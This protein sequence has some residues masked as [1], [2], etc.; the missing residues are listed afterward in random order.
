MLPILRALYDVYGPISVIRNHYYCGLYAVSTELTCRAADCD[1]HLDTWEPSGIPEATHG[2]MFHAAAMEGLIG[3]SIH[4]GIR[5]RLS[6]IVSP[7]QKFSESLSLIKVQQSRS[8][9]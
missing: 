4:L 3:P 8:A 7:S 1:A 2:T 6:G 9:G 5:T